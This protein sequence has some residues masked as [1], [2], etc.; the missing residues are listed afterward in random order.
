LALFVQGGSADF[1]ES[2]VIGTSIEDQL[3]Q[4]SSIQ[5]LL[6]GRN[7]RYGLEANL[8]HGRV[9]FEPHG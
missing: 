8:L 4:P 1:H 7:G 5:R 3:L 6:W 9:I 2:H